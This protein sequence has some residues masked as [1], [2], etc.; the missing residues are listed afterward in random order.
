MTHWFLQ[1]ITTHLTDHSSQTHAGMPYP[2]K[3]L[4]VVKPVHVGHPPSIQSNV[5]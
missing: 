1:C 5:Q 2:N 4:H 3:V